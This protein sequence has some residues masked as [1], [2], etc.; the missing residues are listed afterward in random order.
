[1]A[2]IARVVGREVRTN[3]DG[4]ANKLMLQVE[5]SDPDDIQSVQLMNQSGEETNPPNDSQVIVVSIGESFKVAVAADDNIIPTMAIGERKIYSTS[6]GAVSAFINLLASGVIEINGNGEFAVGFTAMKAAFDQLISDFDL[7]IHSGVTT[8]LGVS[9]PPSAPTT[10]DMT[11]A[12]ID[13]VRL[14]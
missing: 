1:M 2:V 13:D 14:P 4:T 12:K 10:A 6:A 9:G 11:A 7:H 3:K 5:I 8:G